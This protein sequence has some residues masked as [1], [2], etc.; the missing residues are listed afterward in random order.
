[1]SKR[2]VLIVGGGGYVGAELQRH[3][4]DNQFA[5]RVLDT[6]WYPDGRLPPSEHGRTEMIEY[7]Q[8]DF[9]DESALNLALK[10]VTDCIHLAC[11]SNDPSYELDSNLSKSINYEAFKTFLNAVNGSEVN[12]LIYASSSSVYGVKTEPN[13]TEELSCEPRTDYSRFKVACEEFLIANCQEDIICSIL[14]PSTVCGV[15]RR[16]RFDLVVNALTINALANNRIRVDGGAQ[17]RPNLHIK[18]M[19]RA[20]STVLAASDN[21]I[22][23]QI[24]NV[25]GEN[26]RVIEIAELVKTTLSQDIEIEVLPV[27][28]DRSY[29]VSGEK[30]RR[31]LQFEPQF[32]VRDAIK[33]IEE[34]FLKGEFGNVNDA[35]FFNLRTMKLL[36][37]NGSLSA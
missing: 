19:V 6:F 33:D 2:R 20:Y 30:I 26:L 3:L 13:V 22:N 36:L 29:R 5:V 9:R 10:N 12:R 23:R 27:I 25:A 15:S 17:Y 18:D 14:R 1:V 32:S 28:D 37:A 24:F 4:V 34:T 7:V 11:I 31:V 35:K 16:Q 21:L 8:A